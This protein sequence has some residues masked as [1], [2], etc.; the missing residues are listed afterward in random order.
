MLR[1]SALLLPLLSLLA[2][3]SGPV[4]SASAAEDSATGGTS[5][6][7]SGELPT[8]T[9][10]GTSSGGEEVTTGGAE[11]G[12]TGLPQGP[13]LAGVAM[14]HVTGPVGASMAGYGGRTEVNTTPWNDVLNG[15][16]GFYGLGAA[17]AIALE[18]EGERLVLLKMPTMSSEA[19]LTDGVV[20]KLKELHG[21]DLQGRL[22]TGATH[23]HHNVARYWRLPPALA[24]VG[25][26]SPDEE[27]IDRL[28]TELA[29]VVKAALDDLGPA[30]W[31]TAKQDNWDA[32]DHIYRDRRGE[33]DP[34]YGKDPR[35]TL[36]AVRRPDGAPM[37]AV[38]N[39]GMHGTVFDSD[40]ELFTEDAPGGLEMKFEEHFFARTGAPI[41]GMFIQSGGGD[42]SPAGDHLNHPGPA[43]IELIGETAAPKLLALYD[44]IEWRPAARLGVRSRRI[45]L[46]Y[47]GLGY[48]DYHEFEGPGG[49]PYTWGGWQCK[50]DGV[51]DDEDPA[52]SSE[53]KPKNCTDIGALLTGL[54]EP[55]PHGEVHQ[56]YMTVAALDDFYL[57]S[58]PGEPTNSVIQVLRAGLAERGVD[59][60]A[61]GYSQDHMLY[62]THPDDWFQ[63]GYEA[64]MSLWGP[65]AGPYLVGRQMELVEALQAGEGAPVWSEETPNLSLPKPFTPRAIEVS[66]DAGILLTD[67]PIGLERGETMRLAW[68]GGD[69]SLGAPQVVLQVDPGTGK[70]EDVAAPS[71]WPGAVLD[72]SRYHM[73]THYAPDPKPNGTVL[74]SRKHHWYVDFQPPLDLPAG[75]YRLEIRGVASDGAAK[76][77]TLRSVPFAIT[78]SKG[79]EL[80]AT[81]KDGELTLKWQRTPPAYEME[82]TW[83]I[84]GY[85]LL[86]PTVP[87]DM[88]ATLRAPLT[89]HFFKDGEPVGD[90]YAVSYDNGHRFDFAAT[91]LDSA[92]LTVRAHLSADIVPAFI[93]ADVVAQ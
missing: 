22:L 18:V 16:S 32:E 82:N 2:A 34:T 50:A 38:L 26:D 93:E 17:K 73:L 31:G 67:A 58:L 40:N 65:L 77:Y 70:F 54:G 76:P 75:D 10:P 30:E 80:S 71:G 81:L 25:A 63:G 43:R 72:N 56:M 8:T 66:E 28:C 60:M 11:T 3:C 29:A 57:V 9:A 59:G 88:P 79:D 90:D 1:P 85:R 13:L 19:S 51:P 55:L 89:I 91:G 23:S 45:D 35:L 46:S 33:N 14:G 52:T 84:A 44:Q 86:D 27:I 47:D 78:Q 42:A 87:P 36:L 64:E 41:F 5:S 83:P 7:G 61:F 4:V 68:G 24:V 37:A 69:P 21:V 49:T 39:F 62:L 20:T 12:A 74:P 92:G 53:G 48:A 15:S 6:G